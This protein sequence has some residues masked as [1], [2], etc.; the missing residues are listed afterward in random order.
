MAVSWLTFSK[1]MAFSSLANHTRAP[2]R[3]FRILITRALTRPL[4]IVSWARLDL[5]PVTSSEKKG[6]DTI[7]SEEMKPVSLSTLNFLF[8]TMRQKF[9]TLCVMSDTT[10]PTL[11]RFS[12]LQNPLK[13]IL[14]STVVLPGL[15]RRG[16][17]SIQAKSDIFL[18]FST[19]HFVT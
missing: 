18:S 3:D 13:T 12:P 15:G 6:S 11:P 17:V 14:S 9:L 8:S 1:M 19:L 7:D 4:L 16:R 2:S 10:S 5:Q